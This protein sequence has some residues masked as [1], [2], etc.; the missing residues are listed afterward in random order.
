MYIIIGK[1]DFSFTTPSY[2]HIAVMMNVF[3]VYIPDN[4]LTNFDLIEYVTK[5]KIP[6][7]SGGIY[8]R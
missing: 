5:L 7:S 3:G 4:T 8:E 2:L 1:G 6:Y